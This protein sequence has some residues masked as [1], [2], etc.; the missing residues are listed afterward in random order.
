VEGE[1]KSDHKKKGKNTCL[2]KPLSTR[3]KKKNEEGGGARKCSVPEGG[4]GIGSIPITLPALPSFRGTKNQ[5]GRGR[6]VSVRGG[7]H[8]VKKTK[9]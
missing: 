2:V 9:D 4:R 1:E 3:E 7:N 6:R 5:T 8:V